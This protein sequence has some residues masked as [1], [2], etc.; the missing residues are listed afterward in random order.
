VTGA[1]A[2]LGPADRALLDASRTL[3]LAT[4]APDGSP[5][6]VPVCFAVLEDP[7]PTRPRL[8]T[9]LDDKPKAAR[10][11]RALARVRDILARPRVALLAQ[12]WD[13]DWSRLAWL[14]LAGAAS[15]LEPGDASG[16]VAEH[17]AAVRALRSRY[18]QYAGHA[19]EARPLIRVALD[20]A[21]AWSASG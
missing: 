21:R 17:A 9:P 6:L 16:P 8:Y 12:A 1:G 11:P 2:L 13:E 18:P 7:D 14:R 5:R 10:D 20:A 19:L 15:L 3:V 4:L